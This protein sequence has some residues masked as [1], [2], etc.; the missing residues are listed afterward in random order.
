MELP[1]ELEEFIEEYLSLIKNTTYAKKILRKGSINVLSNLRKYINKS[2]TIKMLPLSMDK[3]E[4][5]NFFINLQDLIKESVKIIEDTY[6][7]NIIDDKEVV[8]AFK[9]KTLPEVD[10]LE[11]LLGSENIRSFSVKNKS[12]F[13]IK[14]K[15]KIK[16]SKKEKIVD[17]SYVLLLYLLSEILRKIREYEKSGEADKFSWYINKDKILKSFTVYAY[18]GLSSIDIYEIEI[19]NIHWLYENYFKKDV[20]PFD[21]VKK[22]LNFVK[23]F[24]KDKVIL[25][26]LNKLSYIFLTYRE[27]NEE[28]LDKLYDELFKKA[29]E[30][31]REKRKVFIIPKL[32]SIMINSKVKEVYE[33]G[34]EIGK[35]FR[36]KEEDREFIGRI[37]LALKSERDP[38]S[39]RDKLLNYLITG[40]TLNKNITLPE[41]FF[42][43]DLSRKEFL[44]M[45]N[46]FLAGLWNGSHSMSR[47]ESKS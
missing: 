25:A 30:H 27:V 37:I 13:S 8:F 7:R 38:N 46:S 24:K 2:L 43:S 3:D 12:F 6:T 42:K 33:R 16:K 4:A 34:Y 1:R 20:D 22:V 15:I 36:E 9:I 19:S 35:I 23:E 18:S 45:K 21:F 5:P 29:K 11:L 47:N 31:L 39:F 10:I 26:L 32:H 40:K 44:A 14:S 17:Y 41:E 28:L